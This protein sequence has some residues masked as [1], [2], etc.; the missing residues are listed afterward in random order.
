ME[1]PNPIPVGLPWLSI[2]IA[3]A[4]MEF[5]IEYAKGRM[6]PL[7]NQPLSHMQWV[8]FAVADM[9]IT[10]DSATALAMRGAA[11]NDSK[12]PHAGILHFEA[13]VAANEAAA[14]IAASALKI[15]GGT[16]YLKKLPIERHFRDAVSGQLMAHST[17]VARDFLGKLLLG[18]PPT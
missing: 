12:D 13:K 14:K 2:G 9:A 6:L 7:K 3:R 11:A 1:D 17:E 8:Q 15:S 18:L 16:G 5:A 4:A 10:L